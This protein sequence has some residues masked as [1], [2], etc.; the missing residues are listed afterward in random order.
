MLFLHGIV[1]LTWYGDI[2][3]GS[4]PGVLHLTCEGAA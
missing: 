2:H 4:S 1:F 3:G